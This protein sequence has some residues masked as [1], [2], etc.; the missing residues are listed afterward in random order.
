MGGGT[1]ETRKS[2]DTIV[3]SFLK[4]VN[5]WRMEVMG[6]PDMRGS[7]RWVPECSLEEAMQCEAD[8]RQAANEAGEE[9][10]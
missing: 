2:T 9:E 1:K 10:E 6:L 5:D 3:K 4:A 8:A 7:H